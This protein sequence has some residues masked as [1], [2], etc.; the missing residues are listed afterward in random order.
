MIR[1]KK[2][3]VTILLIF[4]LLIPSIAL[5]EGDY[6]KGDGGSIKDIENY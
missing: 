2:A 4:L 3:I 6:E 5:A 1:T